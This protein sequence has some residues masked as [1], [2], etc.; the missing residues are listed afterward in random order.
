MAFFDALGKT[1]SEK[2][3][4][5]AQKAKV[6]TETMQLK[7]QISTEENNIQLAYREIGKLAYDSQLQAEAEAYSEWFDKVREAKERILELEKKINEVEGIRICQNCGTKIPRDAA[8]CNQC[9]IKS[10]Q[11]APK[12]PESEEP[13]TMVADTEDIEPQEEKKC[14][15]CGEP[16]DEDSRFC[17]ACGAEVTEG[18]T[19]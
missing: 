18:E 6:L 12:L 9:G 19:D 2:G 10:D 13:E 8:F 15:V 17:T 3:K 5:A 7:G 4:E 1:I 14:P 11:G 16:M